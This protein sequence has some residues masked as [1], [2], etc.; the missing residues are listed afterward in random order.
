VTDTAADTP[1]VAPPTPATPAHPPTAGTER[2]RSAA[3]GNGT[4]SGAAKA[5]G[6]SAAKTT[7]ASAS[8]GD[9][10][11]AKAKGPKDKSE[12]AAAPGPQ[13]PP[14]LPPTA[15]ANTDQRGGGQPEKPEAAEKLET[16]EKS[17]S[18]PQGLAKGK[19]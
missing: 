18:E 13:A 8:K 1:A 6:K 12:A 19:A 4:G 3:S 10:E 11:T 2:E 17:E 16:P 15:Q 9:P 5:R 14:E 7:A